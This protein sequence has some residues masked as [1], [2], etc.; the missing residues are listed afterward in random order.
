[1]LTLPS[2]D[3]EANSSSSNGFL[4]LSVFFYGAKIHFRI[5]IRIQHRC[6]MAPEKRHALREF[7]ALIDRYDR[8]CASTASFPI[9]REVFWVGLVETPISE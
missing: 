5:P 6:S 4:H 2:S 1:M 8:E 7:S 3:P 9:D